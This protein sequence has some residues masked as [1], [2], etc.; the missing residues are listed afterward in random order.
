MPLTNSTRIEEIGLQ[1][2]VPL[3]R[4]SDGTVT[5]E[6]LW[7]YKTESTNAEEIHASKVCAD[8]ETNNAFMTKINGLYH[9]AF[10]ADPNLIDSADVWTEVVE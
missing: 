2:G 10:L 9:I 3:A 5:T 6:N 1:L 7:V 8:Y 4:D